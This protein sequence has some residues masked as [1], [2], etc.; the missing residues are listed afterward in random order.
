MRSLSV[1]SIL[2]PVLLTGCLGIMT[3]SAVKPE[4]LDVFGIVFDSSIDYREINGIKG[5]DEPCLRGVERTFDILEIVIAYGHDGQIRKITTR[6]PQNSMFGIHP[7]DPPAV[8]VTRLSG[9][10]FVEESPYHFKKD[11]LL[12]TIL[13]DDTGR[14]FGMTLEATNSTD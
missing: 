9:A 10:G 8:A 3:G 13:V 7:G 4:Q 11:G 1:I 12:L 6:N 5:T 14:L 2:L